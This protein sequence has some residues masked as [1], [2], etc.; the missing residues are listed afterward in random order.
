MI[1]LKLGILE[2][3]ISKVYTVS[4]KTFKAPTDFKQNLIV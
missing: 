3:G 2:L 4:G 1:G